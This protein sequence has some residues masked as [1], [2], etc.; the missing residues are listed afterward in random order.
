MR[1]QK[2]KLNFVQSLP[3]PKSFGED[4]LL[5]HDKVLIKANSHFASWAHQFTA[6]YPV[7]AGESLKNLDYFPHHMKKLV[8]LSHSYNPRLLTLVV[9]GGGSVGDFGGFIASIL[10]RG[11]R[12]VHIPTTW[13]AALDS[14]HGG[15][16][17]L[18]VSQ[19]KNQI[20]TFYPADEI[21]I[22]HKILHSQ[23]KSRALEACGELAKIALIDQSK[24][25]GKSWV[26]QLEVTQG[27]PQQLLSRFLKQAIASKYRVVHKDPYE[28]IG[29]RQ[30]LNLGHT[31]GHVLESF[32]KLPHG[33]AVAQGI[34]FALDWS[35]K[36]D[37]LSKENHSRALNLI[38]N[39]LCLF[40]LNIT[41]KF[42]NKRPSVQN[43]RAILLQDKKRKGCH[44]VTFIF[45][46]DFG[47]PIRKTVLVDQLIEEAYSQGWI[48]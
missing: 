11:V 12:L 45:L 37:L 30:I 34:F 48:G 40:P 38:K 31:L 9:A 1:K 33:I 16:T 28:Q 3:S 44:E 43:A 35:L 15:K 29:H 21:Y 41:P 36:L 4:T 27:T 19:G 46:K 25:Q 13:L 42:K 39:K 17:A 18:N 10:K 14:S 5:I 24:L 23:P 2:S 20:G 8:Q 22:V 26:D 32:M 47:K 6:I 7:K